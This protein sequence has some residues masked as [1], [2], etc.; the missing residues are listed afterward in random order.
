MASVVVASSLA[1]CTEPAPGDEQRETDDGGEAEGVVLWVNSDASSLCAGG[2]E[3]VEIVSRRRDCWDPPLPCTVAQNPPWVLGTSV[4]CSALGGG[5][6]RW[7]V[8]VLQTGRWETQLHALGG[9]AVDGACFGEGGERFANVGRADLD[10][11]A[12]IMLDPVAA[13]NCNIDP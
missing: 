11:N 9:T 12:E 13:A 10:S 1:A 3:R 4:P 2:A 7:E 6:T 8:T 5:A